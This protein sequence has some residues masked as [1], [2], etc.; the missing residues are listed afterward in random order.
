MKQF[1]ALWR[2]LFRQYPRTYIVASF[3]HVWGYLDPFYITKDQLQ[4]N[5]YNKSALGEKDRAVTYSQYVFSEDIQNIVKQ[6]AYMWNKI[7]LLQLF[8]MPGFY[9]WLT[10]FFVIDLLFQNRKRDILLLV[11]PILCILICFVS[12]ING[13]LRYMLPVCAVIPLYFILV[14][15]SVCYK[16]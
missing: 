3:N 8:V 5:F 1:W 10:V 7:P 16:Q 15:N 11:A 9:L 2:S 13:Y 12:P 4:Y 6:Y 14:L